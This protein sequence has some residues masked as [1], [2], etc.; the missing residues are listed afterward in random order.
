MR[1]KI[2]LFV[3]VVFIIL[4]IIGNKKGELWLNAAA[5]AE[6]DLLFN[7]IL[8][9]VVVEKYIQNN[10]ALPT[11]VF[12]KNNDKIKVVIPHEQGSLYNILMVGD[13]I[14]K[15]K[16]SLSISIVRNGS[17]S[18]NYSLQYNCSSPTERRIND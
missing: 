17:I 10:H 16:G 4:F 15:Q 1:L 8:K 3:L 18:I 12:E 7:M 9:H 2:Q 5:C 14:I 11:L 13:S 6:K